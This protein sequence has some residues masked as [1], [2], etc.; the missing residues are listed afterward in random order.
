MHKVLTQCNSTMPWLIFCTSVT[1]VPPQSWAYTRTAATC[2]ASISATAAFWHCHF[3]WYVEWQWARERVRNDYTLTSSSSSDK[4]YQHE[5]WPW[6]VCVRQ[7]L[8]IS[9]QIMRPTAV[10]FTPTN[11]LNVKYTDKPYAAAILE[12]ACR[13]GLDCNIEFVL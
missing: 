8:A 4:I 6:T 12:A 9:L 1:S 10:S 7:G 5:C 13:L 2:V 11:K 3:A